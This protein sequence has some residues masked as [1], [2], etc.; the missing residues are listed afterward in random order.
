MEEIV[1]S[2]YSPPPFDPLVTFVFE[3]LPFGFKKIMVA[4]H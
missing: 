2:F 3:A 1:V 4:A